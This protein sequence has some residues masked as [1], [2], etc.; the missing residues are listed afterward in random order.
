MMSARK[1]PLKSNEPRRTGAARKGE[2]QTPAVGDGEGGR[3]E[4]D[5]GGVMV[6]EEDL[7]ELGIGDATT[8]K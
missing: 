2:V 1:N 7:F 6:S 5:E 3:D 4:A 8:K